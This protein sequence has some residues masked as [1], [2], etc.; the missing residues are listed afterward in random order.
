[1]TKPLSPR[2]P[3]PVPVS[4]PAPP[5]A[6]DTHV[7]LLAG[8]KELPLN[9]DRTEDPSATFLDYLAG[10]R[11]HLAALGIGKGVI[12]QS[13]FY[14][15][16][17]TVT[18]NAIRTLGDGFC[19]IGLLTD[20]ADDRLL[21]RFVS[22]R[23]R[24][25]RLNYVHGGVLTWNGAKRL[26]PRLSER[27]LHIQM[28]VHAD[29]HMADLATDIADCPVPVVFDHIGWPMD[30][31]A[32]PDTPGFRGLCRLL[33]DGHAYVKLSGLY[34][35]SDAPYEAS[36]PFVRALVAANPERCLWGSDWPHIMLNGAEMPKAA[37]LWA[38]FLRAVPD[39]QTRRR[40]LVDNPAALYAL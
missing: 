19:G 36:D 6:C 15:T 29:R 7:H 22:W 18:V 21:D 32:G 17:N 14:G 38:A 8:P 10:Y 24:G 35:L 27:G 1:M 40:I 23:L 2:P 28:L 39:A 20:E 26:A 37:D 33:A 9:P 12:V 25:V 31:S 13:I 3:E 4:H 5:G 34:R 16:D 11:A 30:M